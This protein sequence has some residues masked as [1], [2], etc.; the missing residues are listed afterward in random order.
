MGRR[1]GGDQ[2][3]RAREDGVGDQER[4]AQEVGTRSGGHDKTAW[5]T[6]KT[7]WGTRSRGHERW[8]PEAEGARRRREGPGTRSGGQERRARED[9]VKTTWRAPAW[10]PLL[11]AGRWTG[12]WTGPAH[13]A[14]AASA[15]PSPVDAPPPPHLSPPMPLNPASAHTHTHTHTPNPKPATLH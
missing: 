6:R 4:R 2:K 7:V 15:R 12:E 11:A 14:R 9:G 1:S 3:Q 8:G 10:S 13:P 5:G